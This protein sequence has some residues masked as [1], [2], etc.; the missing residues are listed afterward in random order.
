M[1]EKRPIIGRMSGKCPDSKA[2]IGHKIRKSTGK[3]RILELAQNLR[4]IRVTGQKKVKN[5]RDKW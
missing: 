2:K 4:Y 3:S 1:S 5:K